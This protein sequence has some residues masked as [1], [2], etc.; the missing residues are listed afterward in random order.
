[1][2]RWF[3]SGCRPAGDPGVHSHAQEDHAR[4]RTEDRRRLSVTLALVATYLI[5]EV[6][7]GLWAG[8]LALLA[9]AGHMFSDAGAL[10]LSLFAIWLAQRPSSVERTFG[11]HRVEILAALANGVTL[12][13]VALLILREA[14]LRLSAPRD[15][16]GAPMLIVAV[17]GLIVNLAGLW[18]LRGGKD[19]NLNVRGAW[20]HVLGDTLGS[21]G[22]IAAAF[23][24]W[25][26]GWTW[27]DPIASVGIAL[28]VIY[29]SWHL[30]RETV[31]VLMEAAPGHID[32][33]EVRRALGG[34]PGVLSIHD[35]HVWTITSGFVSLS[36]HVE[37]SRQ[38]PDH[39]LLTALQGLLRERF[40]I[41][42]ATI[43]I[44]PA[45]FERK[46]RIC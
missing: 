9:D 34:T 39:E 25:V 36:C 31:G 2:S 11:Y 23:L 18:M 29:A 14:A 27:A 40:G 8:S 30:I 16:L 44:E 5:A 4:G 45:G 43:Q 46:A 10:A 38:V 42:H 21:I 20:L 6:V 37:S 13:A 28:L 12:V 17:G 33:E 32:V 3:A 24:V 26:F 35:L 1:M 22:V 15:V 41:D 19:S 7:G